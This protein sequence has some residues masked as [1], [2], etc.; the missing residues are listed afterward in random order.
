MS[1][2]VLAVRRF[3]SPPTFLFP[4]SHGSFFRSYNSSRFAHW[5][6]GRISIHASAPFFFDG[7]RLLSRGEFREAC[8]IT[9]RAG[10]I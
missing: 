8:V 5:V 4:N 7:L 2:M 9:E 10:G 1:A 6:R 3:P